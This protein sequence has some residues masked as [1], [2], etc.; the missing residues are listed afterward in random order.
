[1]ASTISSY[2]ACLSY[3]WI[4]EPRTCGEARPHR[5]TRE[6]VGLIHHSPETANHAG[7]TT[8]NADFSNRVACSNAIFVSS[9][10][11]FR[12]QCSVAPRALVSHFSRRA[13]SLIRR[14]YSVAVSDS[15]STSENRSHSA[16]K[17]RLPCELDRLTQ[18]GEGLRRLRG[19]LHPFDVGDQL[20][21]APVVAPRRIPAEA[22]RQGLRNKP[23]R[24]DL[25]RPGPALSR[26]SG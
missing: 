6:V 19:Q 13:S 4:S 12:C 24:V 2:S 17:P 18:A 10:V 22:L 16:R 26:Q 11:N 23:L 15:A 14:S 21:Q 7:L 25:R 5:V 3:S 1:M 20:V 9:G 8:R